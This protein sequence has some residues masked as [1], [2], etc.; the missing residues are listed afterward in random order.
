MKLFHSVRLSVRGHKLG[1]LS[2][3]TK[4]NVK[5]SPTLCLTK[6]YVVDHLIYSLSIE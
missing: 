1:C 6:A 3:F 4:I 2:G 5:W